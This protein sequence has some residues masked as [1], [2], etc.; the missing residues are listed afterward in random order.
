MSNPRRSSSL[1]GDEERLHAAGNARSAQ[2]P[3]RERADWDPEAVQEVMG[4]LAREI[5]SPLTAIEVAVD[6]LGR[7]RPSPPTAA[8]G[9]TEATVNNG[10][11]DRNELGLILE[12]SHRLAG[13]ARTLLAVAHPNTPRQR[14]VELERLVSGVVETLRPDLERANIE[15][16]CPVAGCGLTAWADPHDVRQALLALLG[17]ARLALDNWPGERRIDVTCGDWSDQ[18][19]YVRIKD[20]GPGVPQER[21]A[22]IFL[23]FISGWGR[24][25]VGLAL[26]RLSLLQQGGD[27]L[28]E[29]QQEVPGGAIFTMVLPND[30]RIIGDHEEPR[31]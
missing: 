25:G 1:H 17:N 19:V 4:V 11:E 3:S 10:S 20:S 6:R 5:G 7:C 12:Q 22:K 9:D 18:E 8:T 28:L 24:E 23:P 2:D 15:L 27:L 26:T 21:E 16:V 14:A 30:I 13:L 31:P 29:D